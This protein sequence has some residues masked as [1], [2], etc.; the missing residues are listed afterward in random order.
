MEAFN[1]LND[2]YQGQVIPFLE[3]KEVATIAQLVE[4]NAGISL[5]TSD[6]TAEEDRPG[7]VKISLVPSE[8]LYFHVSYAYTK[9][10]VLPQ[11]VQQFITVLEEME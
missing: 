11:V 2:R 4:K 7:L 9:T 1:R 8:R 5:V 6:L 10:T 3:L